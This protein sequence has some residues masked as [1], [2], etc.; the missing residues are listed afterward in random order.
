[1]LDPF[2][3]LLDTYYIFI[4]YTVERGSALAA[5]DSNGKSDPYVIVE[6]VTAENKNGEWVNIKTS[7]KVTSSVIEKT[8]DPVWNFQAYLL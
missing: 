4:H 5:K 2:F 8:L 6:L 7:Q 1:M 3:Q